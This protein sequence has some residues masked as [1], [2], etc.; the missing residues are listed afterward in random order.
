MLAQDPIKVKGKAK[1]I[2]VYNVLGSKNPV[3]SDRT[4]PHR[5]PG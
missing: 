2:Q 4:L 1:A 5:I 3:D